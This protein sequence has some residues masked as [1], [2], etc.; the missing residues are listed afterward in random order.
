M[1]KTPAEERNCV[2]PL[3]HIQGRGRAREFWPE[4]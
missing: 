4:K 2:S 1:R 3:K